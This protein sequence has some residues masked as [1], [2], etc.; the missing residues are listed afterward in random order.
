MNEY[1][2]GSQVKRVI[3]PVNSGPF[4][5]ETSM[6]ASSNRLPVSRRRYVL[7]ASRL[8]GSPALRACVSRPPTERRRR[9]PSIPRRKAPSRSDDVKAMEPGRDGGQQHTRA[10]ADDKHAGPR[11]VR[12]AGFE[13]AMSWPK[14]DQLLAKGELVFGP[15]C[16]SGVF[17]VEAYKRL[18]LHWRSRNAWAKLGVDVLKELLDLVRGV[19]VEPGAIELAAFSLCLALCDALEPEEIR[20]S[21]R[22]FPKLAGRN[23]TETCFFE[24]KENRPNRNPDRGSC[25]EFSISSPC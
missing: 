12:G 19:D 14:M 1:Q 22:L 11:P 6:A 10:R 9:T 24:A 16:G 13:E 7:A 18:V 20:A 2:P 25:R 15:S 8:S 17:L 21:V 3:G 4:V 5:G 23:L